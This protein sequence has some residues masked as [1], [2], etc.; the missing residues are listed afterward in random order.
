MDGAL[1]LV[2]FIF[3]FEMFFMRIWLEKLLLEASIT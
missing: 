2:E 3:E 1:S